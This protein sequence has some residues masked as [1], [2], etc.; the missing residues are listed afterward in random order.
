MTKNKCDRTLKILSNLLPIA[1]IPPM[2]KE[3]EVLPRRLPNF[4]KVDNFVYLIIKLSFNP[5]RLVNNFFYALCPP[6]C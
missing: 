1:K 5:V 3:A 2:F 6:V 4:G